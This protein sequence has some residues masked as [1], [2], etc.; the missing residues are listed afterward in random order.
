MQSPLNENNS[1]VLDG[2]GN[3]TLKMVPWGGSVTWQPASVSVKC[4][5]LATTTV[6]E[7]KIYIGPSA[8]DQYFVDG[9]I[10]GDSGDS[11]SKVSSYTVDTH[12]NSLWAV[13]T[14]GVRDATATM[15]VNGTYTQP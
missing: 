1:V 9:T 14:G 2:T 6:C 10:S 15:S 11:T 3:G 13:W 5:A 7:C 8:T 12:G 4:N